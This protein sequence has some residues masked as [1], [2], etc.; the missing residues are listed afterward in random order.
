M[1]DTVSPSV[2]AVERI[3]DFR[4]EIDGQIEEAEYLLGIVKHPTEDDM[5]VQELSLT[6]TRELKKVRE[7]LQ[8][9]KMWAGKV[10]ETIGNPFPE[11]LA[12]HSPKRKN[13]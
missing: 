3:K 2:A 12:D 6:S 13:K 7:K 8:E 1:A 10:L 4:K 11:E 5:V 9:A